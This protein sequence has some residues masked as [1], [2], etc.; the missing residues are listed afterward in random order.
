VSEGNERIVESAYKLMR[1]DLNGPADPG[2]C[3][4][5]VRLVVEDAFQLPSHGWYKWLTHRVERAAG[6]DTSP[7][8]R[9]MER[10]MRAGGFAAVGPSEGN[11]YVVRG[12]LAAA[13]EPGDL[14]FRWDVAKTKAGTFV[15]HVGVLLPGQLVLENINPAS[16]ACS[17]VRGSTAVT[18]LSMFPVT[19]AVRFAPDLGGS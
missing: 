7:W 16:R 15:G 5:M 11:R 14:L 3:L 2:F 10:S 6:D 18:P 17:L 13:C 9:D 8:A 4:Q 1:G 19:L 12:Q